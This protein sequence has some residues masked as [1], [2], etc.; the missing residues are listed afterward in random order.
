[1]HLVQIRS[2]DCNRQ[3]SVTVINCFIIIINLIQIIL[4]LLNPIK[5]NLFF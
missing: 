3:H 1:M 4:I 2:Y 5:M